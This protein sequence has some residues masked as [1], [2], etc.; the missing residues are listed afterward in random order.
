LYQALYATEREQEECT[1]NRKFETPFVPLPLAE[2]QTLEAY[3][4]EQGQNLDQQE[5]ANKVEEAPP[6]DQK[7]G[8]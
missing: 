7:P 4:L 5:D 2:A 1:T 6:E 8:T 3:E